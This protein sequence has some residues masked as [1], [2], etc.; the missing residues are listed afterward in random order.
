MTAE[1]DLSRMEDITRLT[2]QLQ[3]ITQ[4]L[5]VQGTAFQQSGEITK[6]MESYAKATMA[7]VALNS[8][9]SIHIAH[10]TGDHAEIRRIPGWMKSH[11]RQALRLSLESGKP[12]D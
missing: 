6:A 2:K 5:T 9:L 3:R 10:L 4:A 7:S 12:Y 11:I 1:F 8:V